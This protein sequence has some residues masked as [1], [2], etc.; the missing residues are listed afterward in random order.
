MTQSIGFASLHDY[1]SYVLVDVSAHG[2]HGVESL[3]P[4]RDDPLCGW[5]YGVKPISIVAVTSVT[6]TQPKS[7]GRKRIIVTQF[8]N[9]F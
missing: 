8:S 1:L 2:V 5:I 4:S 3:V 9:G 6:V 7:G